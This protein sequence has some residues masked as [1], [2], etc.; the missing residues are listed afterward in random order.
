MSQVIQVGG[1]LR[2]TRIEI[3]QPTSSETKTIAISGTS[4]SVIYSYI[5]VGSDFRRQE[6][7]QRETTRQTISRVVL[8]TPDTLVIEFGTATIT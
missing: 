1:R 3:A 8:I 4:L 5:P 7:L 6:L 2:N